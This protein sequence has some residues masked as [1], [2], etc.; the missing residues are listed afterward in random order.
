MPAQPG[1][2]LQAQLLKQAKA[3]AE[4]RGTAR[5]NIGGWNKDFVRLLGKALSAKSSDANDDDDNFGDEPD[6]V[7][8]G[9]SSSAGAPPRPICWGGKRQKP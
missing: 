8:C 4:K 1:L 9:D 5:K 2:V 6:T 7:F 3:V